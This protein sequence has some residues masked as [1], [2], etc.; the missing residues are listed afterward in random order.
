MA[1]APPIAPEI[2]S[3]VAPSVAPGLAP[4]VVQHAASDPLSGLRDW[5]LPDPVSWWP[6]APG[7]WLLAAVLLIVVIIVWRWWLAR[8]RRGAPVRAA[9]SEL[10]RL[11]AKSDPGSV[12][13]RDFAAAVSALLRRLAL[14]RYRRDT[15][16]GLTGAPWLEFLDATG[17]GEGFTRGPGRVLADLPFRAQPDPGTGQG[18]GIEVEA[19]AALAERWIRAQRGIAS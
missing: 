9:R 17:G 12:D 13:P 8:W 10:A 11:R 7:W 6:P 1:Q 15:V 2:T 14:V 18:G 4:Q 16:A 3:G 19:L 5:H